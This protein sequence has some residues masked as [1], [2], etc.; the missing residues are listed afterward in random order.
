MKFFCTY[1]ALFLLCLILPLNIVAQRVN[2]SPK[3]VI[4]YQNYLLKGDSCAMQHDYQQAQ[5]YY[6]KAQ[7]QP[8]ITKLER[9]EAYSRILSM[10]KYQHLDDLVSNARKLE[11]EGYASAALKYYNDAIAYARSENI[12][13]ITPTSDFNLELI[14][15]LSEIETY[16][17]QSRQYEQ[18]ND[19]ERAR[20]SYIAAVTKSSELNSLMKQNNLSPAFSQTINNI[21]D[22]MNHRSEMVVEYREV[23][24]DHYDTLYNLLA[25][26]LQEYLDKSVAIFVPQLTIS[27][28]LD[29]LHFQS[30]FC[31]GMKINYKDNRTDTFLMD[32]R[33]ISFVVFDNPVLENPPQDPSLNQPYIHGFSM[34][35]KTEFHFFDLYKNQIILKARKTQTGIRFAKLYTTYWRVDQEQLIKYQKYIEPFLRKKPNGAYYVRLTHTHFNGTEKRKVELS[36]RK[37]DFL[38]F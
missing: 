6:F 4:P 28:S 7:E 12:N 32:F 13:L 10:K 38:S 26:R 27:L 33:D 30:S 11:A 14:R 8:K 3:T 24:P 9:K 34:P 37:E 15:Q 18:M 20:Q 29:T 25:A 5:Y 1:I 31:E 22:F 36:K 21:Q 35:A 23:F 2:W 19:Q 17:A 16:L